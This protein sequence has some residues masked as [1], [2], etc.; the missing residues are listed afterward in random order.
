MQSA[1]GLPKWS[2]TEV[3]G[4]NKADHQVEPVVEIRTSPNTAPAIEVDLGRVVWKFRFEFCSPDGAPPWWQ[5]KTED[6]PIFV[7]TL[8]PPDGPLEWNLT[9]GE[10]SVTFSPA[11]EQADSKVDTDDTGKTWTCPTCSGT[12]GRPYAKLEYC[13]NEACT[14]WNRVAQLISEYWWSLPLKFVADLARGKHY[15]I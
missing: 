6:Y 9:T 2:M 14:G 10:P 3:D 15:C 12:S 4:T 1:V 8:E 5:S 11:P 13:L 7:P